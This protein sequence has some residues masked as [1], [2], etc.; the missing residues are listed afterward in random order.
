[1]P[2]PRPTAGRSGRDAAPHDAVRQSGVPA[3][4]QSG[5]WP[6]SAAAAIDRARRSS[7]SPRR[8]QLARPPDRTDTGA[9]RDRGTAIGRAGADQET[10]DL[11]AA[12]A[13]GH[14]AVGGAASAGEGRG[15]TPVLGEIGRRGRTATRLLGGMVVR[16]S[17]PT[18]PATERVAAGAQVATIDR[19]R[20][21]SC[22]ARPRHRSRGR[23]S[24][25]GRWAAAAR[26]QGRSRPL[27]TRSIR[28]SVAGMEP[29][30]A[31]LPGVATAG[32][33]LWLPASAVGGSPRR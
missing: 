3:P 30:S 32:I 28:Q 2:A 7:C 10:L 16:R 14:T 26:G 27:I 29:A 8:P 22:S 9:R 1:M 11:L 18:V 31:R 19:A 20:R 13:H 21:S 5:S 33:A 17:G 12:I 4:N 25:R 24:R 23:R 15:G 6:P